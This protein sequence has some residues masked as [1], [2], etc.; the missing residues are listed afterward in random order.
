MKST[1]RRN[2]AH[3]ITTKVTHHL[4]GDDVARILAVDAWY[5]ITDDGQNPDAQVSRAR[6]EE[7]IRAELSA[8]GSDGTMDWAERISS[9]EDEVEAARDWAVAQVR[10]L[11]PDMTVGSL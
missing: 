3:W 10:R 9:D 6:A 1:L 2:G 7:A 5:D 11:W 8:R 4:Q